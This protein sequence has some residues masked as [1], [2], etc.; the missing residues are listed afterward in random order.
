MARWTAR[1]VAE[2]LSGPGRSRSIKC[3]SSWKVCCPAH[4]ETR[5]SMSVMDGEKGVVWRCHVGC[6]QEAVGKALEDVMGG[7]QTIDR[8]EAP[9]FKPKRARIDVQVL[10]PPQDEVAR[11]RP[12][13]FWNHV[14]GNPTRIWLYRN[15]DSSVKHFIA[16]YD[17]QDGKELMPWSWVK[18]GPNEP[19]W[20]PKAMEANRP[21]YNLDEL[22]RRPNDPVLYVEG[23]K[24]ADAAS[25]MFPLWVVTTNS[26][27]SNAL[28]RTDMTPLCG[29]RVIIMPDADA[30]GRKMMMELVRRLA[31]TAKALHELVW[32]TAWPD[33]TP[34]AIDECDDAFDHQGRNWTREKLKGC[35]EAGHN[36]IPPIDHV[37]DFGRIDHDEFFLIV[38]DRGEASLAQKVGGLKHVV[39]GLNEGWSLVAEVVEAD[40]NRRLVEN[41]KMMGG[42]FPR[43]RGEVRLA[44][45]IGYEVAA[46]FH[47][48]QGKPDADLLERWSRWSPYLRKSKGMKLLAT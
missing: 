34:Y 9:A 6:T 48:L 36:L 5:P 21:L 40:V 14:L 44:P 1:E 16:R 22:T 12:E 45:H 8:T 43:R 38:N 13:T 41:S 15:A 19:I 39:Y 11:V 20:K 31:N 47:E 18:V 37:D 35:V 10:T 46:L 17:T 2:R 26:G 23:E 4:A 30:P 28:E 42:R 25:T 33:G 3:G 27:G 7:K 24:A 29:R 32:P